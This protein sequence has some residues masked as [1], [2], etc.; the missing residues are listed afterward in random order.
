[1]CLLLLLQCSQ[2]IIIWSQ[3]PFRFLSFFF[4]LLSFSVLFVCLFVCLFVFSRQGF[5]V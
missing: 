1:V 5:S 4:S 2:N 3:T